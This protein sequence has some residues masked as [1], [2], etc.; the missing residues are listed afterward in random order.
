MKDKLSE[1]VIT[2]PLKVR[3]LFSSIVISDYIYQIIFEITRWK[4]I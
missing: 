1:R 2:Q 3:R 4:F